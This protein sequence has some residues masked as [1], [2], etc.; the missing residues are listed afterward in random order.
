MPPSS[1]DSNTIPANGA[2][3]AAMETKT[4]A[5]ADTSAASRGGLTEGEEVKF[6]ARIPE[7][8][9]DAFS[10]LCDQ[11]GRSMSWVIR[12]WMLEAVEDGETGL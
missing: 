6:N 1:D 8:L 7:N 2:L 10:D 4:E 11:E 3:D 12:Q 9:R 5:N